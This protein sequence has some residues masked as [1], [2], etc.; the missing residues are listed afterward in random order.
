LRTAA[1]DG[2]RRCAERDRPAAIRVRAGAALVQR[3][4]RVRAA[5]GD[6]HRIPADRDA[7]PAPRVVSLARG[8]RRLADDRSRRT[9]LVRAASILRGV[10]LLIAVREGDLENVRRILRQEPQ[11]VSARDN[12]GA[13]PLHYAAESGHREIVRALLDA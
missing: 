10:N 5:G 12:D 13:T 7:V 9:L 11:S 6:L 1:R 3:G 8:H 2:F 4:R